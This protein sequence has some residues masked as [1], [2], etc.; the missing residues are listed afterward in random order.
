MQRRG[1][2]I[3]GW[4]RRLG[5]ALGLRMNRGRRPGEPGLGRTEAAAAQEAPEAPPWAGKAWPDGGEERAGTDPVWTGPFLTL[6]AV[7]FGQ[8][9]GANLLDVGFPLTL[10]HLGGAAYVLGLSYT[11]WAVT[12]SLSGYVAGRDLDRG[13]GSRLALGLGLFVVASVLYA[14]APGPWWVVVGRLA[15]GLG[16]GLYWSEIL[17][18]AGDTPDPRRRMRRL[19]LF[20]AAV[21]LGGVGGALLG[22]LAVAGGVPQTPSW[23]AAVLLAGLAVYALRFRPAPGPGSFGRGPIGRRVRAGG[24]RPDPGR[25]VSGSGTGVAPVLSTPRSPGTLALG[26][27]VLLGLSQLSNLFT[28]V[29]LPLLLRDH[30]LPGSLLGLENAVIV[31]LTLVGQALLAGLAGADPRPRIRA[32][33]AMIVLTLAALVA[34]HHVTFVLLGSVGLLAAEVALLGVV[35]LHAAQVASGGRVG[36]ATGTVRAVSDAIGAASFPLVGVA[37]GALGVVAAI[38]GSL[39]ALC[40]AAVSLP[41][42][43]ARLEPPPDVAIDVH[44]RRESGGPGGKAPPR[45]DREA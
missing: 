16:A 28:G 10:L 30:H 41:R 7:G 4:V 20:N 36:I 42:V 44:V 21:A 22:A 45:T 1:Q 37:E 17:V 14:V 15:Q 8:A 43:G 18:R 39:V 13:P 11:A 32:L 29:G 3:T 19:A 26:L 31:G 12:R 27:G 23:L 40:A 6:L 25:A 24:T 38:M 34:F 35:W 2:R 5:W 33:S 9:L